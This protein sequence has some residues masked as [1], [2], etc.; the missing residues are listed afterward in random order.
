[1]PLCG[2]GKYEVLKTH[3]FW[4]PIFLVTSCLI[5]Q[6][7]ERYPVFKFHM[8]QNASYRHR[9]Q[10]YSKYPYTVCGHEHYR[11][12]R[13][14]NLLEC[15]P[16]KMV[17]GSTELNLFVIIREIRDTPFSLWNL[18]WCCPSRLQESTC[19][20]MVWTLGIEWFAPP[21]VFQSPISLQELLF[22]R[23]YYVLLLCFFN[24]FSFFP[25]TLA[26]HYER[27]RSRRKTNDDE[28][29]V[30]LPFSSS[31]PSLAHHD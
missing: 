27:R 2:C 10:L 16:P 29:T 31:W 3:R 12:S 22:R 13:M 25:A 18:K 14:R 26:S 7:Q 8:K 17:I 19:Q 30:T 20:R 21:P 1:M 11:K 6:N 28:Q 24:T 4:T 15:P 23:S 5:A 9:M